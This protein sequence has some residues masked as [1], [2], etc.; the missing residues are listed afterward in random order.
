MAGREVDEFIDIGDVI[1]RSGLPAS[2]LHL[3]ERR[4]LIV[5]VGREGL[6][7]QYAVDILDV[8]AT[9]VVC[10]RAGFSLTEI[11]ELLAP[12]AFAEG[13]A[14]LEKK[15]AELRRRRRELDLAIRG[16]EHALSCPEPSPLECSGFRS[17]LP[18]VLPVSRLAE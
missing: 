18:E 1:A 10:Q 2:T 3:W 15:L 13:K 6:R 4:G 8:L 9:I 17:K 12:G 16:V 7:R 5:P 14:S 11:G